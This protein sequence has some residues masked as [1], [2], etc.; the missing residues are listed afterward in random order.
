MRR[1]LNLLYWATAC[2][3]TY[4]C[5]CAPQEDA[6]PPA[7]S[8]LELTFALQDLD[9]GDPLESE[10]RYSR[11]TIGGQDDEDALKLATIE[12][13]GTPE[14]VGPNCLIHDEF[15]WGSQPIRLPGV[16]CNGMYQISGRVT[17]D[18]PFRSIRP[19]RGRTGS[20]RSAL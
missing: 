2:A 20:A 1:R 19:S 5:A 7:P 13:V 6:P 18:H 4:L 16:D 9:S 15:Y 8:G 17:V 3:L 11:A 14:G 12:L 10:A